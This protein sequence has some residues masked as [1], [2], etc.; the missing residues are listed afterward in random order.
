[1]D[2]THRWHLLLREWERDLRAENKAENTVR[3]Y[4]AATRALIDWLDRLPSSG[5]VDRP[6]AHH[7]QSRQREQRVPQRVAMVQTGWSP[8][9]IPAHPMA[10]MKPPA[11]PEQP[12]PVS[13]DSW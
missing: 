1:M 10:T 11:V 8:E 5:R 3:V 6:A 12:V 4:G 7:R 9:T 13:P 2:A